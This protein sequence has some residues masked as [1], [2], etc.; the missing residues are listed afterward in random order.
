METMWTRIVPSV[1]VACPY[2]LGKSIEW[3]HPLLATHQLALEESSLLVR[4][5]N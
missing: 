3:K 4:E 1:L 5:I 2:L